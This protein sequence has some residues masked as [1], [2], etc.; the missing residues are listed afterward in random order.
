MLKPDY[1]DGSIVNL[2]SSISKYFGYKSKYKPLKILPAS[3]FEN[4]KNI[5]LIIIDGLGFEFLKKKRENTIFVKYLV[6]PITSVFPSTTATAITTFVTGLPAQQH[7]VTGWFM[8]LKEIGIVSKILPFTSRAG[9]LELNKFITLKD[10]LNQ[11]CFSDKI[12]VNSFIIQKKRIIDSDYNLA[13]SGKSKRLSYI[14]LDGFFKQIRKAAK[15]SNKRKYIYGYWPK[16][17]SLSHDYG[18]NS[19]KVEKHFKELDRKLKKFL[20]DIEGTNSLIIITSDHGFIDTTKEKI[21]MLKQHPKLE[22]CLTL[23]LCGEPRAVFCYVR[24]SKKKQFERYIK[25][26]LKNICY[27]YKSEELVKKNYLGLFK[28]NKKLLDRI[29]DY[30]IILKDNYVL[31]DKI[32]GEKRHYHIGAHGG[33]SKEEMIVPL[34]IIKI[35]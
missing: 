19:K 12:K 6:G 1:K 11:K 4:S 9:D 3:S 10:I 31:K 2:M 16:F 21:I 15:S 30:I 18:V 29:G 32:L 17:D 8:N 33:V 26:K 25:T 23:P 34:I 27:L 7:A 13:T 28:P 14:S 24:P 20:K 5:I 22:E 35:R